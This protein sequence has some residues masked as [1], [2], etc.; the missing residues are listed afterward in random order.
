MQ[1]GRLKRR[2]FVSPAWRCSGLAACGGAQQMADRMRR[3]GILM[4][5]ARGD[6]EYEARV[7]ALRDELGKFG[8]TDGVNIEFDERWTADD[9]DVVRANAA[10]LMASNPD[11]VVAIGGRVVP[12][13]MRLSLSIPIVVPGAGDP[14]GVGWVKS[15]ARPGGNVTGFT[16]IELSLMGKMLEMLKQAMP[17]IARVAFIYNSDN[18]SAMFYRRAFEEAA[19]PLA[20]K[21]RAAPSMGLRISNARS[22]AWTGK[23]LVSCFHPTSRSR[24]CAMRLSP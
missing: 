24:D 17:S 18:P 11:V 22:Q 9:M 3:V 5:Y 6:A 8:W 16:F 12:V 13:L 1:F 23:T 20:I 4:P 7:R 19:G 10:S 21:L 15:L 14:L 2:E